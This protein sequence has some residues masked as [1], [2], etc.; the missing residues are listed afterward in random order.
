MRRKTQ[1]RAEAVLFMQ[2]VSY[3]GICAATSVSNLKQGE[4]LHHTPHSL[5]Y[6]CQSQRAWSTEIHM[7][8]SPLVRRV[9]PLSFLSR[10]LLLAA[11]SRVRITAQVPASML[12]LNGHVCLRKMESCTCVCARVHAALHA[13]WSLLSLLPLMLFPVVSKLPHWCTILSHALFANKDLGFSAYNLKGQ[14]DNSP[15]MVISPILS[16]PLY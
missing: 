1:L 5:F 6:Y 4:S 3:T 15:K 16:S 10:L 11:Y 9:G 7:F 12:C 2:L 13:L 8:L 14:R